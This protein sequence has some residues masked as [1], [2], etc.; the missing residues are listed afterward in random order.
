MLEYWD[1]TK[2]LYLILVGWANNYLFF[3]IW[4]WESPGI[5]YLF[6]YLYFILGGLS[7]LFFILGG[8]SLIIVLIFYIGWPG[9]GW[10]RLRQRA[11]VQGLPLIAS[12]I[13]VSEIKCGVREIIFKLSRAQDPVSEM[14]RSARD[15]LQCVRIC[16]SERE[17]RLGCFVF[18]CFDFV[19][20]LLGRNHSM[21]KPRTLASAPSLERRSIEIECLQN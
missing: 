21:K 1:G 10:A 4:Y 5:I 2:F 12:C 9:P 16:S 20:L 6:L 14:Y 18:L 7:Y 13:H 8:P 19:V 15:K 11:W 3:Y 17:H